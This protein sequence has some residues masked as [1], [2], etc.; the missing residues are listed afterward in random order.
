MITLGYCNCGEVIESCVSGI[1]V[2]DRV[3]SNGP[4][5]EVIW[6]PE[7]LS[8]KVPDNVSD[9]DATFTVIGSISLQGIRLTKPTFGETIVVVGLGLVGLITIQ[10]LKAAGANVISIDVDEKNNSIKN[11]I[12]KWN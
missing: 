8:V 2:G 1:N 11:W 9:D 12:R 5:A 6:I 4:H 10:L 7:K 3:A